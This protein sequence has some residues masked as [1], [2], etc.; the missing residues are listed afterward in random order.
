MYCPGFIMRGL[1]KG[2]KTTKKVTI[3]IPRKLPSVLCF[4]CSLM[5]ACERVIRVRCLLIHAWASAS[6]YT[7]MH[8]LISGW[9]APLFV[10]RDCMLP[11]PSCAMRWRIRNAALLVY[12]F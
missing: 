12:F 4:M 8:Y 10:C 5:R 11:L 6:L 3:N 9:A 1:D 2:Q 7:K